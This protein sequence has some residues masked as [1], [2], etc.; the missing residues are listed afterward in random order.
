[1]SR[2]QQLFELNYPNLWDE[3]NKISTKIQN[4]L[5]YT[6]KNEDNLWNALSIRGSKLPAEQFERL[7]FLGDSIIKSVH[8]ILLYEKSDEFTPKQLTFFRSNLENNEYFG[9]LKEEMHFNQIGKLLGIGILSDSQAADCFEAL[10]GAI[11]IDNGKKFDEMVD[12]I[13]SRTHFEKRMKEIK[14][15][16]WG[17]KDPKSFLH[18]WMQKQYGNE[19]EFEFATINEGSGNATEYK[20]RA[21]IKKRLDGKIELEGPWGEHKPKKKDSEKEAAK[22]VLLNLMENGKLE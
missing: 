4:I 7:E 6:F 16:P 8:G 9:S 1:M 10:I 19:T 17:T 13:K 14:K 15:S 20:S 5:Q 3:F 21:I 12:I 2:F 11:F 18:E 22:A